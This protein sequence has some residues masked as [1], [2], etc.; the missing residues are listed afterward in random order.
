MVPDTCVLFM[1]LHAEPGLP[2]KRDNEAFGNING[3]QAH[4]G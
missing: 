4:V 1:L 3:Q 2:M